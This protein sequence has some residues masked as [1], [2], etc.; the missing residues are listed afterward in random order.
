MSFLKKL[1]QNNPCSGKICNRMRVAYNLDSILKQKNLDNK[2]FS[3]LIDRDV[4]VINE[5]LS[6]DYNF[7]I[8]TLEHIASILNVEVR[9][10]FGG[11]PEKYEFTYFKSGFLTAIN[12]Y[13]EHVGSGENQWTFLRKNVI[14]NLFKKSKK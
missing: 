2:Q 11:D 3:K 14:K 1:S 9:A 12:Y 6:G 10:F 7:R 8:D 5:W 13:N 4:S